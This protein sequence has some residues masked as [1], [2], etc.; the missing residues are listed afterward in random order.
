MCT[1]AI[2]GWW[3]Y[4]AL[5][6]ALSPFDRRAV[7]CILRPCSIRPYPLMSL[8]TRLKG[9]IRSRS[10]PAPAPSRYLGVLYSLL[11][12]QGEITHTKKQPQISRTHLL[13]PVCPGVLAMKRC[14]HLERLCYGSSGLPLSGPP[15]QKIRNVVITSPI[16]SSL[17]SFSFIP[18]D[19]LEVLQEDHEVRFTLPI[20]K[21]YG[22]CA[23]G[24]TYG[25]LKQ[26]V[27]SGTV[28]WAPLRDRF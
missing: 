6:L 17:P 28:I 9:R 19:M 23:V 25:H 8:K 14:T 1:A 12:N 7:V 13:S 2:Y 24:H 16:K 4:E 21:I 20:R 11:H 26:E 15:V 22:M 5:L 10:H 27:Q 3:V 18:Q